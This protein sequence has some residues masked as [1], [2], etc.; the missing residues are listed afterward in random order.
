M[1]KT[2]PEEG[3]DEDVVEV[4]HKMPW[5]GNDDPDQPWFGFQ[6]M[7]GMSGNEIRRQ[8]DEAKEDPLKGAPTSEVLRRLALGA[9]TAAD[10]MTPNPVSVSADAT[11]REAVGFLADK[12]FSAAPVIDEA[13]RPVGVLSQ[14]DVVVHDREKV[15]YVPAAPE[16]RGRSGRRLPEGFQVE[17]VDR[18]RVRNIMTPLVFCVTPETPAGRVVEEMLARNVHH[19]FVVDSDGVL[20]GVI[21]TMDVLRN[22]GG[23]APPVSRPREASYDPW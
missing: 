14:S 2:Q 1:S 13:G 22:L 16:A 10:L 18:T 17:S 11:V 5:C 4:L 20:V 12:G 23:E 21:S 9:E 15:E 8:A 6:A 3:I 7:G 19:L